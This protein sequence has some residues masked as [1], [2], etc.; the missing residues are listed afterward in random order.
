M[1]G[2]RGCVRADGVPLVSKTHSRPSKLKGRR[3]K[4]E[5]AVRHGELTQVAGGDVDRPYA[6]VL[7]PASSEVPLDGGEVTRAV[8]SKGGGGRLEG[9]RAGHP[10]RDGQILLLV[11]R[12]SRGT[13]GSH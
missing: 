13:D 7:L 1:G 6:P 9:C 8:A 2:G 12:K 5:L 4:I 10:L 3:Q 11:G